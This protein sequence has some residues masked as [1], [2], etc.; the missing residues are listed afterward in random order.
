MHEIIFRIIIKLDLYIVMQI[1][2]KLDMLL[3][4][5][6]IDMQ[7]GMA[8]KHTVHRVIVKNPDQY[9]ISQPPCYL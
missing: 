6:Q 1:F 2:D 3:Y 9:A 5:D 8:Q 7:R 4:V